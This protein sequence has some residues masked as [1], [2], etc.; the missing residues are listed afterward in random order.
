MVNFALIGAAGYVAPRHLKAIKATDNRLVAALDP[1]DSVGIL[2][3]Y[4]IDAKFFTEPERFERFLDK[5]RR[6]NSPDKVDYLS[7]CSPNYLHD[8]H[9]RMALRND[10]NAI[11]EKP[12]VINPWNLDALQEIEEETGKKVFTVLQLRLH[13]LLLEFKQRLMAQQTDQ[14][15]DVILSYVTRRGG[16]YDVSWKGSELKS[17]GVAMN[18]G[19]H[20]FDLCIWMFGAVQESYVYLKTSHQMS[21]LLVLERATVRW[22]LSIDK[23]DLPQKALDKGNVAYRSMTVDG[24]EVEF[25]T[26]FTDLHTVVYQKTLANEG[27][28]LEDARPSI[29]TVYDIRHAELSPIQDF[30]HPYL[31]GKRDE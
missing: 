29:Q 4:F 20:F 5:L 3:S 9:I 6:K 16:W 31:M 7:I 11:C 10:A 25:S 23:N 17:G 27:F 28:T 18:I 12:I 2:D 1:N 8:A 24:E 21:G 22:Y 30:V 26:G 15:A 14:K 13:P 19:I